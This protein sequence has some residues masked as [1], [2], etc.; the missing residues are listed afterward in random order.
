MKKDFGFRKKDFG[1]RISG[2]VADVSN[3]PDADWISGEIVRA[4]ERLLLARNPKSEIRN[5]LT[6][7]GE[8]YL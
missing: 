1:F 4:L 2:G 6:L 5:P 7:R 8:L 3:R